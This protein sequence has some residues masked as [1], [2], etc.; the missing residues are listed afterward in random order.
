MKNIKGFT[1]FL[2]EGTEPELNKVDN[3][4]EGDK[5]KFKEGAVKNIHNGSVKIGDL[6]GTVTEIKTPNKTILIKLDKPLKELDY[7][8]NQLIYEE[9][10]LEELENNI[11]LI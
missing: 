10:E 5:V 3:L 8:D 4:K 7:W 6:I 9:D 11:E 2:N 1:E